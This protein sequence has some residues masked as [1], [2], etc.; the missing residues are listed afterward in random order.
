MQPLLDLRKLRERTLKVKVSREQLKS[1]LGG[2]SEFRVLAR[3]WSGSLRFDIGEDVYRVLLKEGEVSAVESRGPATTGSG[4]V[5]ISAPAGDW[6]RFLEPT[7]PPW[8]HE[9]YP[10]SAHHGFRLGG[11]PD[12]LWPY[13]YAIR[14][15]GEVLRSLATV[16]KE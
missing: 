5:V 2:D 1:V 3:Y 6:A 14:R 7:P 15:A 13:Y 8:Y 11:D 4:D 12:Y 10:A 9:F 16:E